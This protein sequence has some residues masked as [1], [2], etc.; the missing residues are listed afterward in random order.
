MIIHLDRQEN[1]FSEIVFN[2]FVNFHYHF[3]HFYFRATLG[4]KEVLQW[5]KIRLRFF[6]IL[7]LHDSNSL[8][9]VLEKMCVC[10]CVS[11]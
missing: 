2:D 6:M 5:S 7:I 1:I 11:V 3:C 4:V 9:C 8:K 10:V